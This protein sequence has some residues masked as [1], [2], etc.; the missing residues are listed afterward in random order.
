MNFKHHLL[1]SSFMLGVSLASSAAAQVNVIEELVV[2]AEKREQSLQD[3][4]VAISAFTAKQR[5]LVGISTVQDL[6]NFTPGFVYQSSNDR[7]SMRGIGRL[8]NVHAV[9]GAVS[10]Y[11]DGLFTTS[12]V[13][14]G[15]PPLDVERVEILRGPQGTLYGRNAIGG[16]VNVISV[17]PTEDFYAEVRAIAE[18]Y[19]FTNLQMAVSG[20]ITDGLRFRVSGYKL[21]Q[22]KGYFKNVNAGMPSEGSKRDEYQVQA[23]LEADLGENADLWVSYKTLVWHNR[24][25]P[26]ARAGYL[27]GPYETGRLDPNFSIVYNSAHGY[28]PE[29]GVNGIVPGSLRQFNGSTVT[30]NPAL[31]DNH[32][33][34]TNIPQRVRLRDVNSL[35]ANFVYHL[36][37]VDVKYVGGIQEYKYDLYGDTDATSV[38]SFQIPLAPGSI[39]GTIGALF[40]A[41]RSSVNC[42]PLTV[43]ANN[44]YHYFEYPKW[45]SHEINISSTHDGPL[46]WIVGAF[47]YNEKYTGTGSTADFFLVGPS[48]LQTPILG[49]RPN[50]ENYW[51]TGNYALTTRSKAVFGQ[52]DWQATEQ[53]KF[54]AGLRYTKDKK[55]GTEYRR[56]VCNSDACYPG[57]YPALGL[58]AFGPGTASNWGSLLG[59]LTALPAVGQALGL[60]NAL[61]P[62][63]GLGNG[64]MDLTDTLAPKS[65]NGLIEGVKTPSVCT[66]GV[67]RQYV[68]G[69]NGIASR[70]LSDTSDAVTGTAGVQWEP[71]DDTMA[72]ARYSRGYKAFGFSAGGFLADPKAD[73]ETVN[74]YE[75]G[76]KKNFGTNLQFNAAVFYLDY[77]NLQAP[78]AVRVGATNVTQFVNIEKS[79]SKGAELSM[80]WRPVDPLRLSVDYG[81]NPTKIKKSLLLVDV[82]DNINTGAVSVVGNALP[83][84]PKHKFAINGTYTFDFEPG[85]LTLGATYLYRSKSYANVFERE[86]NSAPSWDQVDLRAIWT[87]EGGKYTVIAYVKNVLNDD[88]YAAAVAASQRNNSATVASDRFPNGAQVY[89]LTPPRIYGLELQYRF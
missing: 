83:Q 70:E 88:G 32:D 42:S 72:Y 37:T 77:K 28:S 38:Q 31:V 10:I 57:L 85:D 76:L 3:V 26:G 49:A 51:S 34:N 9:D 46:Q 4:P 48:S 1:A 66:A 20:P 24:G 22:R 11:I 87:P 84:A 17:R 40:A 73:A 59:N 61:A 63:G 29:T 12:T 19:D 30:S 58:S 56:I 39:C 68:I 65:T 36:P 71:N 80:I 64:A 41:G 33:F 6:T 60:G 15:G 50:P 47:Y 45:F 16:T 52:V 8:T 69:P 54:T 82:N 79:V 89:E 25:G 43:N 67:C 78:V 35:T 75:L 44:G 5:D 13:L 86:Y 81:Y 27:N 62:L 7:S 18:N 2:T 14:A 53:L 74:A 23:Q 21:D 55:F